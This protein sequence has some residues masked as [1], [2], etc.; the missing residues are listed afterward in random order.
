MP[1]IRS[2]ASAYHTHVVTLI[3]LLGKIMPTCSCTKKKLIYIII[4]ALSSCQPFSYL[5]CT[6]LNIYF[7]YNV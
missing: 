5:K 1:S 3:L 7:S 2:L 6:K 4:M